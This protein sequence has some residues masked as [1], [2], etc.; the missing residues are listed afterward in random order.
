MITL[1]LFVF[2]SAT[3]VQSDKN[4]H[5]QKNK[6]PH[7][8]N[9]G[10]GFEI[11]LAF[12]IVLVRH[13]RFIC[14]MEGFVIA[15]CLFVFVSVQVLRTYKVTKTLTNLGNGFET[16]FAFLFSALLIFLFWLYYTRTKTLTISIWEKV[17]RHSLW[18]FY[19]VPKCF[20]VVIIF[21]IVLFVLILLRTHV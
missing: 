17:L 6:N 9:L 21:L 15:L 10:N 5:V 3:H 16:L 13:D 4:P 14:F 19:L 1:H 20:V 8:L 7:D 2:V 12:Y 18:H 11:F